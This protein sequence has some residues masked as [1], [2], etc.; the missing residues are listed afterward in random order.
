MVFPV[1]GP[2]TYYSGLVCAAAVRLI[3]S[4]DARTAHWYV[5]LAG[6]AAAVLFVFSLKWLSSHKT[7]RRGVWMGEI[8]MA[9]AILATLFL[10]QV[11]HYGWIMT[12]FLIGGGH[13]RTPGLVH[14]HD[15]GTPADRAFPCLWRIGGGD[16]RRGGIL[17]A[18]SAPEPKPDDQHLF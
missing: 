1:F 3:A 14:T 6:I 15:R 7:A 10:P 5:S 12:G 11:H 4:P 9:S 8:G 18:L 16:G 17:S 2:A 13:W